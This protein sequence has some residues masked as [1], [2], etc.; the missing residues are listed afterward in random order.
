M[1][2]TCIR[3]P[4]QLAC[5]VAFTVRVMPALY[6]THPLDRKGSVPEIVLL[7]PLSVDGVLGQRIIANTAIG[8]TEL[9]RW[10]SVW[11]ECI[12]AVEGSGSL[13]RGV[14]QFLAVRGE[15]AH[16]VNPRWTAQR[17]RGLRRPG[18][19]DVLDAQAVARLLRQEV[20]ASHW[21][22]RTRSRAP[23]CNSGVACAT[24]WCW[25]VV[26]PRKNCIQIVARIGTTSGGLAVDLDRFGERL[27]PAPLR[28]PR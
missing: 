21:F 27:G 4:P 22:R 24:I 16:E 7:Q 13:G 15:R 2:R 26:A 20:K 25:I 10:A 6:A 19:S 3:E 23:A 9:L 12:W 18:K 11:P 14:A 5:L 1:G 8:W 28:T 17:R